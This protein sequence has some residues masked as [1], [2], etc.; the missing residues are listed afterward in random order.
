MQFPEYNN[1][2]VNLSNSILWNFGATQK[3]PSLPYLDT[4]LDKGFQNVV[5]MIFDG[6]GVS[7]L[8]YHLPE[9]SFLRKHFRQAIS[10]VFPPTTTAALTSIESGLTPVEHGWLGWSVYFKELD[11]IVELFPNTVKDSGGV[12]AAETNV[13]GKYL[14]VQDIGV[15]IN[16]AGKG[17][18]ITVSPYA[19]Y[20]VT[21]LKDLFSTVR[22]HCGKQGR[23]FV[24]AYWN[25]PDA[26]MHIKGCESEPVREE[27][28]K[29]NQGVEEL[30]S[31]LK[32]TLV[33][34]AADHGHLD[35]RYRFVVEFP[36][37]AETLLRP[38][39]IESRAA[40][41]FVKEE[42]KAA[43]PRKF[44][45]AFGE[46]FLLFSRKEVISKGLFGNGPQNLRFEESIGDYLAVA[47]AD[48]AIAYNRECKQF[49]SAHAGL[50][51]KE[52]NVP[53]IVVEKPALHK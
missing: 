4:I 32:D 35:V 16:R 27:I 42:H 45:E 51:Q 39:S 47:V 14:P 21:K 36:S 8:E 7:A 43:F 18:M 24:Y 20:R 50:T 31:S 25:Q 9:D 53:L 1:S 52:M 22:R 37:V 11:K 40:A 19:G 29:I 2:L 23:K 3:H 49:V 10:S 13:A 15:A 38:P 48:V 44:Q 28:L 12:Q 30:C 6:M 41:F 26:C 33:I 34:V 17:K 5:L 46:E